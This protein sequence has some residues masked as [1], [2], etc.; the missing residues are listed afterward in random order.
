MYF[1]VLAKCG[2]VGRNNYILKWFY[3]KAN[4]GE[5]AAYII[6]NTPRVKHHQKDAIK[7]VQKIS[8]EEYINGLKVMASDKYFHVDNQKDQKKYNCVKPEEIIQ[9][10][11]IIKY[12][13][14]RNGQRLK[15]ELLEKEWKK[16][17]QGGVLYDR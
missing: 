15:N 3:Q 16:E 10:E 14:L 13:K 11:K 4:S 6:R 9:E 8:F 1:K 7:K 17:L 12:K 2:H 5:E